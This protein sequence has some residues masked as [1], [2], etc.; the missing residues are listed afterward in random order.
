MDPDGKK[1][2]RLSD[3]QWELVKSVKDNLVANLNAIVM[4][5]E[6]ANYDIDKVNPQIV[7]IAKKYLTSEFGSLPGDL[8]AL[9]S[10]LK[11]VSK[12]IDRLSRS[13]FKYD[14]AR[15]N[16]YAYTFPL[17]DNIYLCDLYFSASDKGNDTKEGTILHEA[18]HFFWGLATKDHSYYEYDMK[19]LPD[20]K[21]LS[22]ANNWEYF[23]EELMK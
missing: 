7:T 20:G 8:G 13:D 14:D 21:K 10:T 17:F 3:E 16:T 23:Y 2:S 5:I 9:A 1:I 4:Q 22:N 15:E 18:T 6:N 11:A 19:K 12:H